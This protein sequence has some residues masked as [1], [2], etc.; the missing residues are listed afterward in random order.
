MDIATLCLSVLLL[1]IS[2]GCPK[3]HEDNLIFD[4][5]QTNTEVANVSASGYL[6]L[7]VT[8]SL[9]DCNCTLSTPRPDHLHVGLYTDGY[10]PH[11]FNLFAGPVN[12]IAVNAGIVGKGVGNGEISTTQPWQ[13]NLNR[14]WHIKQGSQTSRNES[15][16]L[17][18]SVSNVDVLIKCNAS[19]YKYGRTAS[20]VLKRVTLAL[21]IM[22]PVLL[23]LL[24]TVIVISYGIYS[25]SKSRAEYELTTIPIETQ[26]CSP[27]STPS[28]KRT[29]RINPDVCAGHVTDSD[30]REGEWE[31]PKPPPEAYIVEERCSGS[32]L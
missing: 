18:Y 31:F 27:K 13:L 11:S 29:I 4:I 17:G 32:A 24:L 8:S 25:R 21:A 15:L 6:R 2:H 1:A 5:C 28:L 14:N 16:C 30:S 20:P 7:R 22:V 9:L 19:F 26:K 12:K 3:E 10:F 23:V